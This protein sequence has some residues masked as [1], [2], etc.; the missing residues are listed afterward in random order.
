M[1]LEDATFEAYGYYPRD[2][3]PQSHK[4]ILAYCDM[5]GEFKI[6]SKRVYRT[7]CMSCSHKGKMHTDDAKA[8]MSAAMIG[9]TH[10]DEH[11]R[12]I[13]EGNKGKT[14]TD[15]TKAKMSEA[16]KGDNNSNWQ[17]GISFEPYCIKFNKAYKESIRE[18]F[19]RKCFLC[20]VSEEE[21]S[22]KLDVHH[23]NYNKNCG[24]DSSKCVCVALCHS[25][26][27]K[28]NG[29][30]NYWQALIMEMLKPLIAW[31]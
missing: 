9:K 16:Q 6:T 2:L 13:G 23:V 4:R 10:T 24:C 7:L 31:S 30:R 14:L 19:D 1:I 8:K 11:K 12:K 28:T 18:L 3:K 26:H 17:S 21:N 29:N 5:C 22:K 25:C 20:D 15:E 27:M